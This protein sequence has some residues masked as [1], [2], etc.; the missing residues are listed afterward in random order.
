LGLEK[1]GEIDFLSSIIT[2]YFNYFAPVILLPIVFLF[3]YGLLQTNYHIYKIKH[4]NT[5]EIEKYEQ[6]MTAIINNDTKNQEYTQM[7]AKVLN[8]TNGDTVNKSE[9]LQKISEEF[10]ENAK[11]RIKSIICGNC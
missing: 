6:N 3:L 10:R 2:K 8:T 11:I 7:L 4:A 1:T 9:L 5:K